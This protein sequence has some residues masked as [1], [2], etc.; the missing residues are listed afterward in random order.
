MPSPAYPQDSLAAGLCAA[1]DWWREAGVD[2]DY[3]D[4]PQDWLA[5]APE[6]AAPNNPAAQIFAAA[7]PAQAETPETV[8][9]DPAQF[10][11]DLP[12]FQRWW[13]DEPLLDGGH[14]DA[15]VAPRGAANPKL[16]IIAPQPEPQDAA[17]A[18]LLSGPQGKLLDAML[19]AMGLGKDD[20]YLATALPR[21]MPLPHW[22]LLNA[23][24]LGKVLAHHINLVAPTRVLCLGANILPLLGHE[25]S[26]N[27]ANLLRINQDSASV[28]AKNIPAFATH[29]LGYLLTRPKAKRAIWQNWLKWTA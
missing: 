6:P 22:D 4:D 10:P 18:R 17:H 2:Y 25:P 8:G 21:A 20:Y 15:R 5:K 12:A 16:M 23:Q 3:A 13:M 7:A 14:V 19:I 11:Q 9:L 29:D 28:S 1:L 26:Q 24:G 27:P